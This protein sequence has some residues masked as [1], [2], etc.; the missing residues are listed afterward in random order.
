MISDRHHAQA[1]TDLWRRERLDVVAVQETF[2]DASNKSLASKWLSTFGFTVFWNTNRLANTDGTRARRSGGTAIAIRSTLLFG[3][4][5][6]ALHISNLVFSDDGRLTSAC[7]KWGDHS[8]TCLSLYLPSADGPAQKRFINRHLH[9]DNNTEQLY[10][11]EM[12][13]WLGDFNFVID[14]EL[15]CRSTL[16]SSRPSDVGVS[17]LWA[18][19]SCNL[20]SDVFR[21]HHPGQKKL[22]YF[23]H[24]GGARL[25]RIYASSKVL[26]YLSH[27]SIPAFTTSDHRLVKVALLPKG[28]AGNQPDWKAARRLKI[29]ID[30]LSDCDTKAAFGSWLPT[31]SA[32]LPSSPEDIVEWV[33]EQWPV[34]QGKLQSL[35]ATARM[36]TLK[37]AKAYVPG[38]TVKQLMELIDRGVEVDFTRLIGAQNAHRAALVLDV[39]QSA[40]RDR[41]VGVHEKECASVFLT[42]ALK[43]AVSKGTD[44]IP[45]VRLS[46]G[47]LTSDP[48][49]M[50]TE[51]INF[52]ASIS[53]LRPPALTADTD[54]AKILTAMTECGHPRLSRSDD[55]FKEMDLAG[56]SVSEGQVA[57]ALKHFKRRT[58]AG[59]DGIRPE[60]FTTFGSTFTPLFSKIFSAILSI[61]TAPRGFMDGIVIYIIRGP[62]SVALSVIIVLSLFSTRST[63]CS[64]KLWPTF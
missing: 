54:L 27:S 30:F 53:A 3:D 40:H 33:E 13:L 6:A 63:G 15:D 26:Q 31:W 52:T 16:A 19:S 7:I 20:M 29:G 51:A 58:S 59:P 62:G 60:V 39:Y 32:T 5:D 45:A 56:S 14:P 50:A 2:V 38:E 24:H 44:A 57:V 10:A 61:K 4:A 42:R 21:S 64:L 23:S 37:A 12:H 35:N 49:A 36:A 55:V 41:L 11:R 46:D 18:S 34:L 28:P 22:T 48:V 43:R 47:H 17:A 25:D 1:T 9:S 8:V